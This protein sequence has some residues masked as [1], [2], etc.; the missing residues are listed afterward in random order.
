MTSHQDFG[1]KMLQSRIV[2]VSRIIKCKLIYNYIISQTAFGGVSTIYR[3]RS[4]LQSLYVYKQRRNVEVRLSLN[5]YIPVYMRS[6]FDWI[7]VLLKSAHMQAQRRYITAPHR[8]KTTTPAHIPHKPGCIGSIWISLIDSQK[9][10][11]DD[12]S[13]NAVRMSSLIKGTIIESLEKDARGW[14]KSVEFESLI[15]ELAE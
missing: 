9:L 10:K 15:V 1:K 5:W 6:K 14:E 3:L 2:T 11:H 12:S 13:N 7:N 4:T 8:D